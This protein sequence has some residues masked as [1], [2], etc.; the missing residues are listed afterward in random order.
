MRPRHPI[1][2]TPKEIEG[3]ELLSAPELNRVHFSI[4]HTILTPKRLEE[5]DRD[6]S[7]PAKKADGSPVVTLSVNVKN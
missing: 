4:N 3:A 6:E 2:I 7:S 1:H 5:A